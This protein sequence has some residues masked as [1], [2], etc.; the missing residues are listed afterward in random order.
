MKAVSSFDH[1]ESQ[2][3]LDQKVDTDSTR[4]LMYSLILRCLPFAGNL[5]CLYSLLQV[6]TVGDFTVT[7]QVCS[8]QLIVV[9]AHSSLQ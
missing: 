7:I 9:L 2:L 5:T 3:Q 4:F 8:L 1:E 6:E